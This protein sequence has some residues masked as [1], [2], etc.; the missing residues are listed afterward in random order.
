MGEHWASELSG[1]G[2]AWLHLDLDALDEAA[3]PA[4]SY[5]QP[6]GLDW[7]SLVAIARPLLAS[8]ALVGISVA[9]FNP[10]LDEEGVYARRVVQALAEIV[11]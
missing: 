4:V 3:L 11:R 5:P 8:Q 7:D 2:S 6:D 9:D 10:D 1:S